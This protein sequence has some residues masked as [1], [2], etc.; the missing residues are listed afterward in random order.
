ML[1][2]SGIFCLD[3]NAFLFILENNEFYVDQTDNFA[4]NV[5]T[6]LT[7][8]LRLDNSVTRD[9]VVTEDA[10]IVACVTINSLHL[11]TLN[12]S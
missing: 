11:S 10:M 4:I 6:Q 2:I 5:C 8:I 7:K 1:A 9:L 12:P 3:I